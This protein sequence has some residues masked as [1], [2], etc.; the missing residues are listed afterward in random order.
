MS[1]SDLLKACKEIDGFQ[2]E[3]TFL[4]AALRVKKFNWPSSGQYFYEPLKSLEEIYTAID[5][6]HTLFKA[7]VNYK[8]EMELSI[9]FECFKSIF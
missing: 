3:G 2:G 4:L 9:D 8:F 7:N 1:G 6:N 5:I